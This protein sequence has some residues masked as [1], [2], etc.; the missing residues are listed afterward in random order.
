[1]Q[2]KPRDPRAGIFTRPVVAMLLVAGVWSG[3]VTLGLFTLLLASG[4]PVGDVM[5]ITFVTLVLIQFFN[6]YNCRSDR[7]P[8]VRA[9]LANRWLNL[10]VA[11]EIV[12]LAIIVYTPFLQAPFGTFS[13]APGDVLLAGAAAFTVVPAVE[14]V[15]GMARRGWFGELR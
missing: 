9:P 11:W 8:I 1:M 13:L 7:L 5:A 14:I 12:L 4:R 3:V 6:A 15:K 2:R 10:A